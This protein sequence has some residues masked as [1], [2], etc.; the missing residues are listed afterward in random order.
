MPALSSFQWIGV[1]VITNHSLLKDYQANNFI[2]PKRRLFISSLGSTNM[3]KG[4]ATKAVK[5]WVQFSRCEEKGLCWRGARYSM[6]KGNWSYWCRR[7]KRVEPCR[8][9]MIFPKIVGFHVNLGTLTS[10]S[11]LSR[12]RLSHP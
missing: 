6:H 4:N 7:K 10:I 12:A 9:I 11:G 3:D 1:R 2:N 8:R 5:I